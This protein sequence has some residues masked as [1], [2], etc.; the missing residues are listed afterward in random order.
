MLAVGC[1]LGPLVGGMLT[2]LFDFAKATSSF[3]LFL[4]VFGFFYLI[5]ANIL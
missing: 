4:I 5:L 2:E 1:G 3:G